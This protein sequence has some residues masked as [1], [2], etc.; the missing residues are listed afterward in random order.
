MITLRHSLRHSFRCDRLFRPTRTENICVMI[1]DYGFSKKVS[2]LVVR[3]IFVDFP[4]GTCRQA[5]WSDLAERCLVEHSLSIRIM[6]ID[7]PSVPAC[8]H[9]YG[10]FRE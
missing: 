7:S 2:S 3:V 1:E 5:S 8:V 10:A 6:L 9:G 4:T